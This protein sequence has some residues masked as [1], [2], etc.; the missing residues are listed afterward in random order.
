MRK[1]FVKKIEGEGG[2]ACKKNIEGREESDCKNRGE[3]GKHFLKKNDAG[4]HGRKS[5]HVCLFRDLTSFGCTTTMPVLPV[6]RI[7]E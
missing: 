2:S 5:W 3:G 6:S 4:R 7:A 1:A